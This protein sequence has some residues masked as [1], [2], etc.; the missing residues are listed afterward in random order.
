[1]SRRITRREFIKYG[2]AV[3]GSATLVNGVLYSLLS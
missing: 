3:L 2:A 1:M